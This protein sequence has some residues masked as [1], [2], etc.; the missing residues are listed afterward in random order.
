MKFQESIIKR[1]VECLVARDMQK[2]IFFLVYANGIK[3]LLCEKGRYMNALLMA[4]R[5]RFAFFPSLIAILC[6]MCSPTGTL[7]APAITSVEGTVGNGEMITITGTGFGS[8]GP[9]VAIFD[10]FEKGTN[11][12]VISIASGSAS[13]NQWS[14]VS[15]DYKP[16][17]STIQAHSGSKSLLI[18]FSQQ[19]RWTQVHFSGASRVYF[20]FWLL[21]PSNSCV[22]GV[23][24][25]DGPNWKFAMISGNPWPASDHTTVFL[26][27]L[28]N[29]AF[30]TMSVWYDSA[31]IN[32]GGWGSS[33]IIKARWQRY[34]WYFYGH[35]S[36]GIIQG[37]E[38]NSS[39]VRTQI[40]NQ[41]NVYNLHSHDLWGLVQFPA[42][43]RQDSVAKNYY[44]DIYVATGAG[45]LAR[46]EIGNN[47]TYSRCTNLAVITPVSW[48]SN[49]ITATVRQGS[50][51]AG[52][53]AYLFIID[54]AGV[55]SPGYPVIIG[56]GG[57]S[58]APAPS[59][60]SAPTGLKIITN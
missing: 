56:S 54:A 4:N 15:P 1:K 58:F 27:D 28:P 48:G 18:D 19:G 26:S 21:V 33:S 2:C 46:V 34:E 41:L 38:L 57:N 12:S 30:T 39:T 45:A 23:N 36:A 29:P 9:T 53:S 59:T 60:I 42:Y 50:F 40:Q 37:W 44:D 8:T 25:P 11:G 3:K 5:N 22:P 17:Y 35:T 6:F 47:S 14:V 51:T 55:V 43:A 32:T 20:S 31:G 49:S 7:A 16:T 24:N 52:S 13:V 10:D